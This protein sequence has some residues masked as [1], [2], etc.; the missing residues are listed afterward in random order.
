ME[1]LL[2]V[3]F[4]ERNK[5]DLCHFVSMNAP[6]LQGWYHFIFPWLNNIENSLWN[7]TL[8]ENHPDP[9]KVENAT[10]KISCILTR[11]VLF[12]KPVSD[13]FGRGV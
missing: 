8:H 7:Q 13:E 11:A 5:S 3:V 4:R 1:N 10:S 6:V 2:V 12:E 9:E